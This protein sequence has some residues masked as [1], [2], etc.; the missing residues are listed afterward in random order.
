[1]HE[2]SESL[3]HTD[4]KFRGVSWSL[5]NIDGESKR[6]KVYRSKAMYDLVKRT[7]LMNRRSKYG[8]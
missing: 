5:E 2:V 4:Y 6:D 1:M 7:F 3:T 8:K